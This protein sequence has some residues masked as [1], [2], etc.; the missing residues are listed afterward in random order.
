[1]RQYI[2]F[3]DAHIQAAINGK[4]DYPKESA[5]LKTR[6]RVIQALKD[7]KTIEEVYIQC[8]TRFGTITGGVM[9]ALGHASQ[10]TTQAVR[11][12]FRIILGD[13]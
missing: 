6:E 7:G 8:I 10:S 3:A 12:G 5:E 9:A 2:K 1:M 4:F 11:K 13:E